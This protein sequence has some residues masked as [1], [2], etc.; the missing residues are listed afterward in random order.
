MSTRRAP[1]AGVFGPYSAEK[2]VLANEAGQVAYCTRCPHHGRRTVL[3]QKTDAIGRV[4]ERCPV[5]DGVS[6][7]R[8][9]NPDEVLRPQALIGKAQLLPPCPPGRLRCQSCAYPVVGDARLCPKCE[10]P[11]LARGDVS[12][13]QRERE[14]REAAAAPPRPRP[15]MPRPLFPDR[16][17]LSRTPAE[18][19][20]KAAKPGDLARAVAR[21]ERERT[22]RP[23]PVK[24]RTCLNCGRQSPHTGG[25][26]EIKDCD[27]CVPKVHGTHG[28]RVYKPKP[29][30]KPGCGVT[31]QPTGPRSKFCEA[32]S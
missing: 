26:R 9:Y 1:A 13:M 23:A 15:E 16:S 10:L 25:P 14:E 11:G 28:A 6:P 27:V 18:A 24:L 17:S 20:R 21:E 31:F 3:V 30:D 12:R 4:T 32:H 22:A 5:C 2:G 7:P 19:A 8:Q 29:C